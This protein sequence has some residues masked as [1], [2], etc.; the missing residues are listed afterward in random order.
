MRMQ[1]DMDKGRELFNVVQGTKQSMITPQFL[2][3]KIRIILPKV[4]VVRIKTKHTNN[5]ALINCYYREF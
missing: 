5:P 4:S 3:V 2:A 1:G